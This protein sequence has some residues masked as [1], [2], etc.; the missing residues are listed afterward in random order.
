MEQK[1]YE[2]IIAKNFLDT[3]PS[4]LACQLRPF[5]D[6]IK[7]FSSFI[8]C[9][10]SQSPRIMALFAFCSWHFLPTKFPSLFCMLTPCLS[11]YI[12]WIVFLIPLVKINYSRLWKPTSSLFIFKYKTCSSVTQII[13][14]ANFLLCY[15]VQR[16]FC[17]I[18]SPFT[19]KTTAKG[20]FCSGQLVKPEI[21]E[22]WERENL[23][24]L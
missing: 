1:Q 18:L 24:S 13:L 10:L 16:R 8:F 2:E 12:F 7:Q 17:G 3:K 21:T 11:L 23:I 4:S 15:T 14:S 20:N 5:T 19:G 22:V 6:W 9:L